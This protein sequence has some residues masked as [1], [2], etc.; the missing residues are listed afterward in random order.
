MKTFSLVKFLN[1]KPISKNAKTIN[2][3][4][5][6]IEKILGVPIILGEISGAWKERGIFVKEN[7]DYTFLSRMYSD[8]EKDGRG[9]IILSRGVSNDSILIDKGEFNYAIKFGLGGGG[10]GIFDEFYLDIPSEKDVFH[11]REGFILYD[12]L[13]NIS[14]IYK[15]RKVN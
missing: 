4:S 6:V 10:N 12:H 3:D 9:N 15:V 13:L 2:E 7:E 5:S 1:V 14:G 8:P 11:L